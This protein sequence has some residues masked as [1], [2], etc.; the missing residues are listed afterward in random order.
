MT[1]T[2]QKNQEAQVK[3]KD[4]PSLMHHLVLTIENHLTY[5][6]EDEVTAKVWKELKYSGIAK[7]EYHTLERVAHMLA[8]TEQE[9]MTIGPVIQTLFERVTVLNYYY[10]LV[11]VN[12]KSVRITRKVIN[13]MKKFFDQLRNQAS[14]LPKAK[15]M[16]Q[17]TLTQAFPHATEDKGEDESG[18]N[19]VTV[20]ESKVQETDEITVT[21]AAKGD[22]LDQAVTV[23]EKTNNEDED[24]FTKPKPKNTVSMKSMVLTLTAV[25]TDNSFGLLADSSTTSKDFEQELV[26]EGLSLS[27]SQSSPRSAPK[28]NLVPKL[29]DATI[30]KINSLITSGLQNTATVSELTNWINSD[31]GPA[32]SEFVQDILEKESQSTVIRVER[33][34][35]RVQRELREKLIKAALETETLITSHIH[36]ESNRATEQS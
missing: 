28:L 19:V 34:F 6:E 32:I 31:A 27:S 12:P 2:L 15:A 23:E 17:T 21:E 25:K 11:K 3:Q 22:T 26:Q 24:G 30:K 13:D 35:T 9:N 16:V 4:F 14:E 29:D 10:D 18:L 20:V 8:I 7:S 33:R 36:R 1:V 5:T